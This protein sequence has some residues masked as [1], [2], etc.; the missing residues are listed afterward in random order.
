MHAT[1]AAPDEDLPI[2]APDHADEPSPL[3]LTPDDI[4]IEL[5]HLILGPHVKRPEF[6]F[7]RLNEQHEVYTVNP[8]DR[9]RE[10]IKP[11]DYSEIADLCHQIQFDLKTC[12]GKLHTEPIRRRVKYFFKCE[13]TAW[14]WQPQWAK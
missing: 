13:A 9:Y 10:H 7:W 14:R 12:T 3:H 4:S 6:H 11:V 5:S 8:A 2:V 1:L